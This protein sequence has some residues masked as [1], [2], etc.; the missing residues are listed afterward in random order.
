M[1]ATHAYNDFESSDRCS[2][3]AT[4]ACD[5]FESSNG[6]TMA[7][8]RGYDTLIATITMILSAGMGTADVLVGSKLVCA[9]P[10]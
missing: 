9:D 4:H 2:M 1:A 3:A 10:V 7:A 8:T 6:C 5:D